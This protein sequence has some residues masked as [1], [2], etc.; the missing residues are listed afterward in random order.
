[1]TLAIKLFLQRKNASPAYFQCMIIIKASLSE[2]DT[3]L[4]N[5]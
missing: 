3:F 2:T 1:M 4:A 5:D